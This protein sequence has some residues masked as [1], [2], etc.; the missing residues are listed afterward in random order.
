ML[1]AVCFWVSITAADPWD[2]TDIQSIVASGS[3]VTGNAQ[4]SKNLVITPT[5]LIKNVNSYVTIAEATYIK[6]EIFTQ[7]TYYENNH[8]YT[9]ASDFIQTLKFPVSSPVLINQ[10]YNLKWDKSNINNPQTQVKSLTLIPGL[11]TGPEAIGFDSNHPEDFLKEMMQQSFGTGLK[12]EVNWNWERSDSAD[13]VS[14]TWGKKTLVQ[15][16]V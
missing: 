10:N 1:I 6:A 5:N 9:E 14:C 11:K 16:Q 2:T 8:K 4:L 12:G 13:G 3:I 15:G 7:T